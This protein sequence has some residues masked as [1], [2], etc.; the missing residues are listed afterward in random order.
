MF[1]AL[2]RSLLRAYSQLPSVWLPTSLEGEPAARLVL[3]GAMEQTNNYVVK[4][5][6]EMAMFA[7]LFFGMLDPATGV[8]HYVN[9]GH[10]PPVIVGSSGVKRRLQPTSVAIGILED[11]EFSI[12]QVELEPGDCLLAFTDGVNEA[13]NAQNEPFGEGRMLTL[14]AN[15]TNGAGALLDS[16]MQEVEAHIGTIGQLDDISLLAVSRARG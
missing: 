15:G 5:H 3:R 4:N 11:A 2:S 6:G 1:M 8:L 16:L 14:A 7:T 9:S 10:E 13:R 12:E